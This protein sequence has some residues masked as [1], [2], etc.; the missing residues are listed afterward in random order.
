MDI[1]GLDS[2][3]GPRTEESRVNGGR[4]PGAG[5]RG[6]PRAEEVRKSKKKISEY[7]M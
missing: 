6:Q 7:T 4:E 5:C 3:E 1:G 2:V